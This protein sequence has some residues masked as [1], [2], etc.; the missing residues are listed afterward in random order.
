MTWWENLFSGF[1]TTGNKNVRKPVQE[2]C[3]YDAN[4]GELDSPQFL[5]EIEVE[6]F[7][8]DG[9]RVW[10]QRVWTTWSPTGMKEVL[11]TWGFDKN[12]KIWTYR[13]VNPLKLGGL[14]GGGRGEGWCIWEEEVGE[15]E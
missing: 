12:N 10:W 9:G 11:E 6:G 7:T 8:F 1:N 2:H 5:D 3:G 13:I 4:T 15:K 14:G